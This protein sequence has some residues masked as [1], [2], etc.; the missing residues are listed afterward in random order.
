[1]GI[2]RKYEYNA[3]LEQIASDYARR[4]AKQ[5]AWL[6]G[7]SAA[8]SDEVNRYYQRKVKKLYRRHGV[9]K[10]GWFGKFIDWLFGNN[11]SNHKKG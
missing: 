8:D 7:N 1:M 2:G 4:K 10:K 11:E 6:R 5:S 3:Q 9:R